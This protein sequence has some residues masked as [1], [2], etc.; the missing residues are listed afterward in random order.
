M[1]ASRPCPA[2]GFYDART[3]DWQIGSSISRAARCQFYVSQTARPGG[4]VLEL[5][6]GTGDIS[7]AVAR[8]GAHV[9]GIDSSPD[10]IRAA[11][12]KARR[13]GQTTA[14][15]VQARMEAFAFRCR[16]TA[17]IIP[18]HALFHVV[19]RAELDELL[20][21]IHAHL[22]PGGA[23]LADIF[24]RAAEAPI[25]RKATSSTVT[26]DGI[27]RVDEHEQFDAATGRLHTEFTYQLIH[28]D[29]TYVTD[30][31]VRHLDYLVTKPDIL[32]QRLRE[33][34][35]VSVTH[36]AAFDPARP[37]QPGEDAVL[38]GVRPS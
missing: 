21:R 8:H 27:Y 9:I 5:G 6:C 4:R 23:F 10:M 3:Y 38:F 2:D 17:V 30:T 7:L 14:L 20:A 33:A 13:Q 35:F 12:D 1:N 25:C 24:T 28:R 32:A 36:F 22:E 26:P 37:T 11:R 19:D 31:W 34:G 29:S 16:F 18:Y 15:W